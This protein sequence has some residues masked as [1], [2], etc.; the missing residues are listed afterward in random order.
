MSGTVARTQAAAAAPLAEPWIERIDAIAPR[1]FDARYRRPRRPV[2]VRDALRGWSAPQRFTPEF[3]RREFG[4][5]KVR[6]RGRM[7][8]LGDVIAQQ[9]QSDA[10]HPAPYPCTLGDC[11]A[12]IPDLTP[13]FECALPNRHTSALMPRRVFELVNHLEVFFGGP[14]GEFPYLHYDMLHMH[15]WIAQVYGDKEFTLYEPGQEALLYVNPRM[16]WVSVVDDLHDR[17][18]FPLLERARRHTVVVHAGEAL[19]IPCGVWHTA[20]C[21]SLNVTVAFDQLEATNWSEFVGDV[22][23]EDRRSGHPLRARALG[24][25]LRLLG[26]LMSAAERLGAN[27]R[28]DWGVA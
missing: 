27:R 1:A 3:F 16:P 23:A 15:T 7:Y 5:R 20:R 28:A 25:Y 12:L 8:R 13:R 26:P 6:V 24:A 18:R 14:G 17:E 22:V 11:A 10:A 9:E 4:D 19:F 2:V 21:L